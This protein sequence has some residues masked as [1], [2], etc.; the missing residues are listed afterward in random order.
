M[1]DGANISKWALIVAN[2]LG[3]ARHAKD[4]EGCFIGAVDYIFERILARS[5]HLQV[6]NKSGGGGFEMLDASDVAGE[7]AASE[8]GRRLCGRRPQSFRYP[9][10]F[11]RPSA[12]ICCLIYEA[13]FQKESRLLL[14]Y[15]KSFAAWRFSF[16]LYHGR[17]I[18][19]A[20]GGL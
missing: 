11:R 18:E 5:L 10:A 15:S 17:V 16:L 12:P 20:G 19:V 4:G 3:V 14:P 2:V 1:T 9:H 13:T 6:S 7:R 8:A